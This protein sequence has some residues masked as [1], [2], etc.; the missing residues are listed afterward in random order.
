MFPRISVIVLI[1]TLTLGCGSGVDKSRQYAAR[2]DEYFAA[3]RFEAAVIEYRNALK[4]QP[5]WA[6]A[7]IK[8]GDAYAAL[9][10]PEEAYRA[11][12][13]ANELTPGDTR[14]YLGMGRLLLDAGMYNEARM[15]AELVLDRDP[16][17]VDALLLYGRALVRQNRFKE[18]IGAFN[19]ALPIDQRPAAYEG[20]GQAKLGTGDAVGAETSYRAGVEA[21]P[22]SV[23]VRVALGQFL[24]NA[25]RTGE[26]E[27][28]LVKA[29]QDNA[30]DELANRAAASL[31]VTTGR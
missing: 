28:E 18:A 9:G 1:A 23:Q 27:K 6:E 20:L 2:G 16:R 10:K 24:L 25:N 5:R 19:T 13:G 12:A 3:D 22:R 29:V 30:D 15:R 7:Y 14:C 4:N 26:A 17:N 31:F 8:L 21:N 11:Y